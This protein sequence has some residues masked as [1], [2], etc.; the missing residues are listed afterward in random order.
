MLRIYDLT[1]WTVLLFDQRGCGK[2]KPFL[3]LRHNTTWDLVADIEALRTQVLG[4]DQWFV[5][6][7]SW[8]TTLALAYAQTHPTRV[9]GLL[10]R[11]LCF[12]DDVAMRWLYE[13]GGASEVYPEAWRHFV[14]VLPAGLKAASWQKIARHFHK[15]LRSRHAATAM[16][17]AHAWWDWESAL[18]FLVPR[19]DD[20]TE[21]EV[22]ALAT[23][24]N[25]YFVHDCWLKEGELL[26]G[27]H[28]L[29]HIPITIVHGRYDMVCPIS[30]VTTFQRILPHTKVVITLAGHASS[31]VPTLAAQKTALRT[32]A[33]IPTLA[34]QKAAIKA[35]ANRKTTR[36]TRKRK[37]IQP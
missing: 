8:G 32:M 22:L 5:S 11:G 15:G 29:R 25:H 23:I 13:A 31:E 10:L 26:R 24:E 18:S 30:A 27:L 14:A 17:Y 16:R 34:A 37:T 35:M 21:Q 7:G 4:V 33:K 20:A 6:G 28:V 3:E 1:R 36:A 19:P 12:C 9:T 2:S